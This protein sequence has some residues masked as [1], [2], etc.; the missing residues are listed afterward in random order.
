MPQL[1][2][3]RDRVREDEM[4]VVNGEHKKRALSPGLSSEAARSGAPP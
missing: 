1:F 4:I 3:H 2:E